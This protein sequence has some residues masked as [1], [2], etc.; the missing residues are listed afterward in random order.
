MVGF[1]GVFGLLIMGVINAC[2]TFVPCTFGVSAC[3]FNHKGMPFFE[4]PD[5]YLAEIGKDWFLMLFVILGSLSIFAF[6]IAGVSVTKYINSLARS[7]A[8]VT[9]TVVIWLVGVVITLELSSNRPN[10]NW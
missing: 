7:I 9:R 1:E 2:F 6:N 4:R 10:Y 3:V 8:D 5:S